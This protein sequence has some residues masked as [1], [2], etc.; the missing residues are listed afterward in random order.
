MKK[1]TLI[2]LLGLVAAAPAYARTQQA[3]ASV[4]KRR[5]YYTEHLPEAKKLL[6]A[7][8]AKGFDNINGEEKIKCEA[9][10]DAWH[11][12]PY[13]AKP[14]TFSSSGGRH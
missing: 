2:A 7:C 3:A 6:Q 10:R 14:S 4:K 9:A 12:Q 5:N 11:F 1:L 13:K 8:V